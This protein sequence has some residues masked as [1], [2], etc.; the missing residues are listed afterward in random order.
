MRREH[1]ASYFGR[2]AMHE[3]S[4]RSGSVAGEKVLHRLRRTRD[5]NKLER[6]N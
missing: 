1:S 5:L 4:M 3:S 2:A 6:G